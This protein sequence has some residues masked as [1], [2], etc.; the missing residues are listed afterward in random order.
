M[1]ESRG[2][3]SEKVETLWQGMRE[4][5]DKVR[6]GEGMHGQAAGRLRQQQ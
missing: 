1:R 4:G 3:R 5:G 6:K 2:G